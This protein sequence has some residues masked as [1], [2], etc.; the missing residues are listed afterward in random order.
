MKM[1]IVTMSDVD[2]ESV[3]SALIADNYRVTRI[4]STGTFWRSGTSTLFFGV[5]DDQVEDAIQCIQK[6]V[7]PTIEPGLQR[8]S[9]FVIN[10]ENFQ[11]V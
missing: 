10:V 8:A 9:L 1:I 7:A 3:T 2:E 4:A 11:Q 5:E 6:N